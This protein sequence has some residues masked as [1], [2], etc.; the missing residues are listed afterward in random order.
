[1]I[2]NGRRP[3]YFGKWKTTSISWQMEDNFNIFSIE[4]DLIFFEMEDDLSL[5]C[6]RKTTSIY[7][8]W[9]TTSI[10]SINGRRPINIKLRSS[11]I[12]KINIE[13]VFH[14]QNELR[15]SPISNFCLES[16][17]PSAG[18]S[19]FPPNTCPPIHS[20]RCLQSDRHFTFKAL[21]RSV[22]KLETSC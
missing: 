16:E 11:S 20:E 13:V 7:V 17:L 5:F 2:I 4:D 6:K 22:L 8:Q 18:G 15:S 21:A 9:K 12:Y 10:V 19:P 14:W 3:Q 1:M